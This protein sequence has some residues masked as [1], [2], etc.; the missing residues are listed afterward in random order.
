MLY[1]WYYA[2]PTLP[3][4]A[5][6]KKNIY[7]ETTNFLLNQ[8]N[9]YIL[10][11]T[12][13]INTFLLYIIC[14]AKILLSASSLLSNV[15]LKSGIPLGVLIPAPAMMITFVILPALISAAISPT[16]GCW[17]FVEYNRPWYLKNN[18]LKTMLKTG[19]D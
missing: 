14:I 11:K 7:Y 19:L 13:L 10:N 2:K 18:L 3:V 17:L 9:Q 4:S 12:K 5:F 16:L 8:L 6:S 15:Y 1:S